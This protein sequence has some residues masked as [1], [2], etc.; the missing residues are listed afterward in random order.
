MRGPTKANRVGCSGR[1]LEHPNIVRYLGLCVHV[2]GAYLVTELIDG[3]NLRCAA[4]TSDSCLSLHL[5]W[6]FWFASSAQG[7]ARPR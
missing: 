7:T 4:W 2:T 5:R 1:L 3:G 6:L